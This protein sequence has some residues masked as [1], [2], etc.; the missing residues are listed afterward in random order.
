MLE[1][2]VDSQYLVT[3]QILQCVRDK[4]TM[5][6]GDLPLCLLHNRISGHVRRAEHVSTE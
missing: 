5:R 4:G 2:G 3:H 6:E 1:I